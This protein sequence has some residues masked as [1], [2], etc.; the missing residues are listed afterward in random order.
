[1]VTWYEELTHLKKPWCRER[2]K[3]GGEGENR[4]WDCWM[5]SPTQWT[6]VCASSRSSWWAGKPDVLQS[7][8]SQRVGNDW[9]TELKDKP[10][11]TVEK[12]NSGLGFYV[13]VKPWLNYL[14]KFLA[15][16]HFTEDEDFWIRY[17]TCGR[18]ILL[19]RKTNTIL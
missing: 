3:A 12:R 18:F 8:G 13:F 1:M 2:L 19:Y 17:T 14:I 6:W 5:S 16:F 11:S 15:S 9:V 7:V 4:G 10:D